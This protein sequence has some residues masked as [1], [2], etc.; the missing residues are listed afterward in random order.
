MKGYAIALVIIVIAGF[1]F[2]GLIIYRNF[3][4]DS[5]KVSFVLNTANM[6]EA[7]SRAVDSTMGPA[8]VAGYFGD[9]SDDLNNA[10]PRTD[11]FVCVSVNQSDSSK[12]DTVLLLDTRLL[13]G[14]GNLDAPEKYWTQIK[15]AKRLSKCRVLI[16]ESLI[17][18]LRTYKY[19]Y[20]KVELVMEDNSK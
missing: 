2:I 13:N 16:P 10:I 8:V 15:P 4:H 5:K 12:T 3:P 17:K 19:R 6:I 7:E 20:G 9:K 1:S 18:K 14:S 11:V